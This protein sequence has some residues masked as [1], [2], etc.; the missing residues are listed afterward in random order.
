[1]NISVAKTETLLLSR[2]PGQCTLY[3]SGVPLKQVEKFKYRGV[4]FTN[5]GRQDIELDTRIAAAG[6]VI[7]QLQR[8]VLLRRELGVKAK[9]A[10][11]K[12]V[13][14][15]IL[16]YGHEPWVMTE[17]TQSRIQAAEMAFLRRISGLTMLNRVRSSEIQETL[18]VEPLFLQI[19]RSQLRYYGHVMRMSSDRIANKV[20]K[21]HPKGRRPRGRPRMRLSD[22][23]RN[24][25]QSRLGIC[26]DVLLEI[27]SEKWHW[28]ERL[29]T[30]PPQPL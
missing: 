21:T 3:V 2:R 27:A 5:D 24:L 25:V 15:P 20:L 28:R 9:L 30:L 23:I 19:E 6:A 4:V 11:F 29:Q 18:R 10:I 12:S 22:Y 16:T 8:S 14:V 26:P 7:R 13:F 17:R 1:M